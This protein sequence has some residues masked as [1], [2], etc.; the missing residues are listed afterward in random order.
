MYAVVGVRVDIVLPQLPETR[1]VMSRTIVISDIHGHLTA[2]TALIKIIG[3]EPSDTLV[4]L[5]D[6]VDR[7]P[8]SKGVLEQLIDLTKHFNVVPLMGNHEE[9]MLM[10]REGKSDCKFW[11][12]CGGAYALISYGGT[13]DLIPKEHFKFLES[14]KYY[15]E[16]DTH[17]FVHANYVSTLQLNK[18]PIDTMLWTPLINPVIHCSGKTAIVGHSIQRDV[19]D[20][21]FLQCIDTGCG[22]GGVLTAMDAKSKQV[23]QV[24][25]NG[26]VD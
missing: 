10:A 14:L 4:F 13:L 15:Y 17:F 2:L 8:N 3:P 6:Y 26:Q 7:G 1:K 23:W 24:K 12:R 19:L 16:T 21:G 5:G 20:L 11:E 18:L 9:M 25:E 22:Y